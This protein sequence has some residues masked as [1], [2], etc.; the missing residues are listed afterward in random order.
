MIIAGPSLSSGQE[1]MVRK[2]DVALFR[3]ASGSLACRQI[4]A[5]NFPK[6]CEIANT[7]MKQC[8]KSQL[9]QVQPFF[10]LIYHPHNEANQT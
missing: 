7:S 9:I 3:T 1:P 4:L 8:T 2:P 6:H 10:Q 5:D